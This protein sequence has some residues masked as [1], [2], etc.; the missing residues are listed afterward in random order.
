MM[1]I[2]TLLVSLLLCLGLSACQFGPDAQQVGEALGKLYVHGDST[3]SGILSDWDTKQIAD[4][5]EQ[6]L[7][8]QIKDNLSDLGDLEIGEGQLQAVKDSMMGA[9][10][11]IPIE[12]E[13]VESSDETATV[14][15]TVGS[16]DISSIDSKA[17]Q[18]AMKSM[19]GIREP[20]EEDLKEFV[21]IYIEALQTGLENADPSEEQ[22]S[23]EVTFKRAS[24]FW[25][26]DDMK[27]FIQVLGGQIRR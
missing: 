18:I 22:S 21:K 26:P 27:A 20:N 13:V 4:N 23:F 12:V 5:I 25:Q 19:E 1:K 17:A 2:K 15:F 7:Y 8:L 10:R 16:L 11:R 14:R 6:E 24:G 9:R 3:V